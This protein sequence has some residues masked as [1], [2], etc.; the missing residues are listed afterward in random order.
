VRLTR[1]RRTALALLLLA[2]CFPAAA[3]DPEFKAGGVALVLPGLSADF[4]EVGDKLRTTLFELL[5]PASNRLLSAYV[6]SRSLTALNSGKGLGGLDIY[7]MVEVPRQ[8]EYTD[9]TPQLFAEVMKGME[10][11]MGNLD[12]KT[13]ENVEQELSVRLKSM[14]AASVE[15]G[16][17]EMLGGLFRKPD[18]ASVAMLVAYKQGERSVTMANGIAFLRVRQRLIFV[19]LFRK[20]ESPDTVSWLRKNLEPWVDAILAKNK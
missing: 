3:A 1:T 11:S 18:A 8:S 19:Y 14:G 7:A 5:T 20:Y 15:I 17:P 6:P 10:S 16:H 4:M 13:L 12:A 2:A 9:V